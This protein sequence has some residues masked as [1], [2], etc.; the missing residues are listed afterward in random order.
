MVN[1]STIDIPRIIILKHE[2]D[3]AQLILRKRTSSIR[4]IQ[5]KN[6]RVQIHTHTHTIYTRLY[7]TI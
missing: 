3:N 5:S 4:Q 2:T 6:V 7:N 1:I